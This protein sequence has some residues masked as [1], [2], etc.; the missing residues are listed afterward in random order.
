[1]TAYTFNSGIPASGNNPSN[2]QPLMLSNNVSNN[3]IWTV[4]H[5]GFNSV[6][7]GGAGSSGG[8]HN[9][10]TYNNIFAPSTLPQNPISIA[11]TANASAPSGVLINL[12]ISSATTNAQNF[13]CNQNGVF[14][15]N[16]IRAFGMFTVPATPS[17]ALTFTNGFNIVTGIGSSFL[18]STQK[19][20]T[21]T[22]V[23]GATNGT[24][25]IPI[26]FVPPA[27]ISS[28]YTVTTTANTLIITQGLITKPTYSFLILQV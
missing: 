4:D 9:Q 10:I 6:G 28:T 12:P 20:I 16:A 11:F 14:P 25:F 24:N 3:S 22:F 23:T 13:F 21:I 2:D 19:I 1:M 15:I 5:V 18:D 27:T 26:I 7:S 17:T 8:Q